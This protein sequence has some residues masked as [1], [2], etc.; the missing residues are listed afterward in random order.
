MIRV[1]SHTHSTCSHDGTSTLREMAESAISRGM[2]HLYL[3]EHADTL[4]DKEGNPCTNFMGN[5]MMEAR[6]SLPDGIR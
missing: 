3:T 6:K 5:S 4:F 1:D 2:T